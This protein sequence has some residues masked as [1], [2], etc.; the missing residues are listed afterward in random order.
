MTEYGGGRPDPAVL[1]YLDFETTG[2]DPF[3][4]DRICEVGLVRVRNG[5]VEAEFS[6]LVNPGRPI[7]PGAAAVNGLTDRMLAGAPRFGE[8]LPRLLELI[9]GAVLV[10]HNAPFDLNFLAAELGRLG[11]P[12]PGN[13]ALDTLKLVRRHYRFASNSLRAVA[14]ELGLGFQHP[15]RALT[16][17]YTTK[18]VLEWLVFD[19]TGSAEI[20][21]NRVFLLQGGP[22][23]PEMRPV[24]CLP[25]DLEEAV[26]LRRRLVVHYVDGRGAPTSRLI[27][28]LDVFAQGGAVYLVAFCHLRGESRTFRLD[29]IVRYQPA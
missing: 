24:V 18:A 29:R 20:D 21:P 19:L 25:P 8:L 26:R 28:P 17:A 11:V 13:P 16:D 12:Y 3:S 23:Y 9:A 6:S 1:V 14:Q 22:V 27:E 10:G 5:Q 2:L 4:G 7:S 15:H